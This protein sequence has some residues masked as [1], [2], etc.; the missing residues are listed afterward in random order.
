M[1][2][3]LKSTQIALEQK[4]MFIGDRLDLYYDNKTTMLGLHTPTKAE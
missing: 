2:F 3:I 1:I 4:E